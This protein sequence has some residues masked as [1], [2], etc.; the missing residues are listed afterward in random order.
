MIITFKTE[1]SAAHF[2]HQPKWN[3]QK[4]IEQFGK[5]FTP[6]G[7]GHNYHLYIDFPYDS[8]VFSNL[9]DFQKSQQK[10]L[11]LIGEELDHKHLNHDIDFFKTHIPTTEN[12]SVYVLDRVRKNSQVEPIKL[13]LKEM[14]SLWTEIQL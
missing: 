2:Y 8:K 11:D 13:K 9:E 4:N 14:D 12:I 7:H 6:F 3:S 1:F 5:C 10:V